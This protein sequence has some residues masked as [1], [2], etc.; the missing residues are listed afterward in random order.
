MIQKIRSHY[1]YGDPRHEDFIEDG[2]RESFT[3]CLEGIIDKEVSSFEIDIHLTT[4]KDVDDL[5]KD[6]KHLRKILPAK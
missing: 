5:S 4:K 2:I 6:L 1:L 3:A